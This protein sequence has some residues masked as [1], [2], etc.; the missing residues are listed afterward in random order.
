MTKQI[1]DYGC[2]LAINSAINSAINLAL[3]MASTEK[4][5]VK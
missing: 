3:I 5:M 4:M 1:N 2:D